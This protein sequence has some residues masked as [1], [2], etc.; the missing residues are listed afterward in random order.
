MSFSPDQVVAELSSSFQEVNG[1]DL[2]ISSICSGFGQFSV[3]LIR[4]IVSYF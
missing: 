3:Y 2:K 4:N 1:L